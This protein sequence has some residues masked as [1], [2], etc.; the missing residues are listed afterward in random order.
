MKM[1]TEREQERAP[2]SRRVSDRRREQTDW[3]VVHESSAPRNRF[4][5]RHTAC[6]CPPRV[7]SSCGLTDDDAESEYEQSIVDVEISILQPIRI[8]VR[9]ESIT[10][11]RTA[12]HRRGADERIK[13]K[14]LKEDC[15]DVRM[16]S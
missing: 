12:T 14:R 7:S 3:R 5:A 1:P 15:A 9:L 16:R 2:V 8:L 6:A 11:R 4:L 13:E 10:G